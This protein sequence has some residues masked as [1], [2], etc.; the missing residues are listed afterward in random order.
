MI[1]PLINP[2]W[3]LK[4]IF[5]GTFLTVPFYVGT[6]GIKNKYIKYGLLL[7]FMYL[8][9]KITIFYTSMLGG[10]LAY[11]I[12]HENIHYPIMGILCLL[13]FC[14]MTFLSFGN[15]DC[16]RAF[17]FVVGFS[18]LPKTQDFL[19]NKIFLWLG[20]ISFEIYLLH[21]L[22]ISSLGCNMVLSLGYTTLSVC[23]ILAVCLCVVLCSA[24]IL[25]EIDMKL[26]AFMVKTIDN[27]IK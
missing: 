10:V 16:V 5:V 27:V 25:K 19:D 4:Y 12:Y 2:L 18:L 20:G 22:V 3:M 9:S 6:R 13:I 14:G 11:Y 17:V 21:S 23:W 26:D 24:T 8:L 15:I 1:T 7:I